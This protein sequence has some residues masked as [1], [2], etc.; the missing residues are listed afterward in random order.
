MTLIWFLFF[1]AK[2][3]FPQLQLTGKYKLTIFYKNFKL[4]E[5]RD[6]TQALREKALRDFKNNDVNVLVSTDVCA[7]GIDIKNLD[8]VNLL[9]FNIKLI[10][11]FRLLIWICQMMQLHMF[12][13]LAAL[14]V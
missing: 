6:R 3:E 10:C 11:N 12:I 7:R 14:V 1:Y 8:H 5:F 13:E 2:M 9:K 4:H